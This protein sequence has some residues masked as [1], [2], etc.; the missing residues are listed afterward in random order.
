[1]DMD[2]LRAELT[3]DEGLRLKPYR[4]TTGNTTIGIGRNLSGVGISLAEANALLD[5]DISRAVAD[6][7]RNL[8]WWK[9]LDGVRQRVLVNMAFNLGINGLLGFRHTLDA[10]RAGNFEA[11]ANGMLASLWAKQVGQRATRLAVMM[12][13]GA[14]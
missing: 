5:S 11:A 14:A 13:T 6:L 3:R 2:T 1:M 4:D 12:R 7:D 10:I 9:S 8:P